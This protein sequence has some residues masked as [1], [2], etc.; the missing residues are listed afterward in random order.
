MIRRGSVTP[1]ESETRIYFERR[2]ISHDIQT[3]V[4]ES[5]DSTLRGS[6]FLEK[7]IVLVQILNRFVIKSEDFYLT[8]RLLGR[9]I[10][11]REILKYIR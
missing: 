3:Q 11:Y 2:V 8:N 10:L 4:A 7:R 9:Y 1:I 6:N 5:Y